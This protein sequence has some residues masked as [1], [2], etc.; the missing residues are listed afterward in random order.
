[1]KAKGLY[2]NLVKELNDVSDA[3]FISSFLH[4]T[5]RYNDEEIFN[6]MQDIRYGKEL[7]K[8][9]NNK[10]IND[11]QLTRREYIAMEINSE[12]ADYGCRKRITDPEVIKFARDFE[13]N[14]FTP[15]GR[16]I[17]YAFYQKMGMDVDYDEIFAD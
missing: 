9:I 5:S 13:N 17:M 15:T 16:D 12:T 3:A 4:C 7:S 6:R 8:Y 14:P 1:M 11:I 10:N 2:K